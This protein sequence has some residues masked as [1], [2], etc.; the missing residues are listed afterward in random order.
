M[1]NYLNIA[2]TVAAVTALAACGGGGGGDSGGSAAAGGNAKNTAPTAVAGSA[3]TVKVGALVTLDGSA[4]TDPEKAEL[5]YTWTLTTKPTGS[6]VYLSDSGLVKA[7]IANTMA[8]TYLASLVVNDGT[9]DSAPSTVLVTVNALIGAEIAPP[10]APVQVEIDYLI[11]TATD[12]IPLWLKSP[13]TFKIASTP[14]WAYYD[15]IGEPTQGAVTV[16]FDSQNG[17][18]ALIRNKAICPANWSNRG[19]WQNT[20]QSNL[21]LCFFY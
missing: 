5:K 20:I 12:N 11:K 13:S 4:S 9:S 8:G 2:L 3:K 10:R 7:T 19:F 17:F 1:K 18:G 16:D 15:S 14:T 6:A 21:A